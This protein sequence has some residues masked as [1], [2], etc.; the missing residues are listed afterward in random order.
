MLSEQPINFSLRSILMARDD[1]LFTSLRWYLNSIY[2][3]VETNSFKYLYAQGTSPFCLMAHVDTLRNNRK[4]LRLFSIDDCVVNK[5]GLLGADDRAGIHA[6]IKLI[7]TRYEK[8]YELPSII[9]TNYEEVGF[10]GIKQFIHDKVLK[11]PNFPRFCINLDRQGYR[12]YVTYGFDLP[13]NIRFL[14]SL[15]ILEHV[16]SRS[17]ADNAFLTDSYGIPS[18]NMSIGYYN[19][20]TE[21][22]RLNLTHHKKMIKLINNLIDL[23]IF[24]RASR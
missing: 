21:E 4:P 13:A 9:I 7:E 5:N 17:C 19:E 15:F 6:I 3:K 14:L 1:E 22:E 8:H 10:W 16:E 24:G 23:D 11:K 18:I 2:P 12:E 20:H